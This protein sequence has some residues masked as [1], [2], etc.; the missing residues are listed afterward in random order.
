[1]IL[2]VCGGR[3]WS[4]RERTFQA[5]DTV[6]RR[7]GV[8]QLI[9]GCARGADSLA[10]EWATTRGVAHRV[11]RADWEGLGRRAGSV[12]NQRMLDDGRPDG[13]VAF[14]GGVGTADM[15]R[16]ALE[17]GVTVWQP[18]TTREPTP[19]NR[20]SIAPSGSSASKR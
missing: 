15:V 12:R 10:V 4:D 17:A 13:V 16:R 7:R 9:T 2:L 14:P 6:Q 5:L 1:M 20:P 11:F 3:A 19:R 18:Y 8:E